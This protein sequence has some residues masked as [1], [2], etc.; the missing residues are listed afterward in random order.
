MDHV[1]MFLF[2]GIHRPE[3]GA[4]DPP[5]LFRKSERLVVPRRHARIICLSVVF[6]IAIIAGRNV[7]LFVVIVSAR[8]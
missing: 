6:G 4:P 3:R 2:E 7:V 5:G 8:G 1:A